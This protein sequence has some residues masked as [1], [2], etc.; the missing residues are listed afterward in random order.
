MDGYNDVISIASK[1]SLLWPI[2]IVS[3]TFEELI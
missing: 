1:C 3:E 2:S